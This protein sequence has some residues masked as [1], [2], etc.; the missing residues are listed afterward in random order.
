M[1]YLTWKMTVDWSIDVLFEHPFVYIYVLHGTW[2]GSRLIHF[3]HTELLSSIL[4][5]ICMRWSIFDLGYSSYDMWLHGCT[6]DVWDYYWWAHLDDALLWYLPWYLG[7]ELHSMTEVEYN[8]ANM[9]SYVARWRSSL[10]SHLNRIWI[11]H[12]YIMMTKFGNRLVD[13]PTYSWEWV[14]FIYWD[15]DVVQD[16]LKL[17][18]CI[19]LRGRINLV[20]YFIIFFYYK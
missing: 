11:W 2:N 17:V 3:I 15:S 8:V 18:V 10:Q 13:N 19:S 20:V 9:T 4:Q 5:N 6:D 7:W 12:G 1:L 14:T 16:K